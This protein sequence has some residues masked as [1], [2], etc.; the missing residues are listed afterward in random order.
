MYS[1]AG[2]EGESRKMVGGEEMMSLGTVEFNDLNIDL[3]G[4]EGWLKGKGSGDRVDKRWGKAVEK[5]EK[6]EEEYKEHQ[7]R[8]FSIE[9][10]NEPSP[11]HYR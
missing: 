6:S 10:E 8:H 5:E 3:D 7:E 2:E 11:Q 9:D 4:N 1:P